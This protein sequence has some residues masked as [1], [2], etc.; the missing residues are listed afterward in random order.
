[1]RALAI[2]D[3]PGILMLLSDILADMNVEVTEA[4]D[5]QMGWEII[6]TETPFDVV[7]IDWMTPRM[8]G[9][10]LLKLIRSNARYKD[11]VL[12]MVTGLTEVDEVSQALQS[13]ANEYL[14]KPFTKEMLED[15]LKLCGVPL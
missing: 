7:L 5:C 12:L 6:E 2:D 10:E 14:M 1:M 15:K 8:S 4:T 13:G 11:V 9:L 3:N